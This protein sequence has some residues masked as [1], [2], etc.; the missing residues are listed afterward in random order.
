[1][2]KT[3]DARSL[4]EVNRELQEQLT[5][6]KRELL[7]RAQ[8]SGEE[9]HERYRA[10]F[11]Q[12]AV[13]V[14]RMADDGR[15]LEV[16][17][18]LCEIVG[19][20]EAELRELTSQEI[21]HPDDV[22]RDLE[23]VRQILAGEVQ[24]FSMEKR[25]IRKDRSLVW[26][27]LTVSLVRDAAETPRY[28]ILIVEDISGRKAAEERLKN[29]ERLLE[30]IFDLLP[31]GLWIV[32]RHGK[33]QRG[34]P[35]GVEI[36][37][38]E[39]HVAPEEY[40]V[41]KARRL[42]SREELGAGD[43]AL[44]RTIS[45]G[46]TI[47]DELI[48]I[49]A[50]DGRKK[51]ILNYTAPVLDDQGEIEGAIIVNQDVTDRAR[52]EASLRESEHQWR[53]YVENAPYGVFVCDAS[54]RYLQVN[55]QGCRM[56][57]Y[58]EEELLGMETRDLLPPRSRPAAEDHLARLV[59]TGEAVGDLLFETRAGEPRW[60]TV[61]AVKL[62]E[63][64]FLGFTDDITERRRLQAQLIQA[65]KMESIG[66]L[67]GGVA[68]DFNNMLSVIIGTAELAQARIPKNRPVWSDFKTILDAAHR[69]ARISRQLLAF[70]RKQD[71]VPEVMDL[72]ATITEMLRV[73]GRLIGEDIEL[74]WE[75][76]SDF[77][78]V[79]MDPSQVDQ[80]LANLAVNARDAIPGV[81]RIFI[82]VQNAALHEVLRTEQVDLPAGEYV[83]L[84]VSDTGSGM[85][86][87]ALRNAFDPFFTT[88][89]EGE[90][91]GLGLAT[92]YGIV[93]QNDGFV[94][95]RN[96]SDGGARIDVYLPRRDSGSRGVPG[97]VETEE[98]GGD[99]EVIL[100][101][102]ADDSVLEI[103][104]SLLEGLG[105]RVLTASTP[106]EA[107]TLARTCGA[108][109]DLLLTDVVL[110]EMNGRELA[111]RLVADI[112]ALKCLFMSGYPADT[113]VEEVELDRSI[114]FIPRPATR[115]VLAARVRDV[116][117]A[118]GD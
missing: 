66:R 57:G 83:Q 101:V 86:P 30:K 97:E 28:F 104:R 49:D 20:S 110:P 67:A 43:W 114:N 15:W 73:L 10:I 32:D 65:Q 117:R 46:V 91:T 116:L 51:I 111:E 14:G 16:N 21:T 84:T 38:A 58:S 61:A 95:A 68:H 79:L 12:A 18:K 102:E 45:E 60:A 2:A 82:T 5:R 50:F 7:E 4:R 103:S 25:Y 59:R 107:L 48:E 39:P 23:L 44:A 98:V 70:A 88:K 63:E 56:T 118:G 76:R 6:L 34:N 17:R 62:S 53:S 36:W 69:S 27:N 74:V 78:P 100:L 22:N 72:S 31:V 24:T 112:P 54:G 81:G 26:V 77:W 64:R 1:M 96:E 37:G 109:I 90:G 42:P 3:D 106:A 92:V 13:G 8:P 35:A 99:G 85:S 29:H 115:Q 108:E 11:E 55:P 113:L 71:I 9:W 93:K 89:K 75:P 19:Y 40:G 94:T 33:L 87:E 80:I 47:V 52:A 105:Y 41:F